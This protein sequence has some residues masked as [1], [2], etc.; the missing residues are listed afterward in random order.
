M[1]IYSWDDA[2]FLD[3]SNEPFR[4][5]IWKKAPILAKPE[6]IPDEDAEDEVEA[7]GEG[8]E[9]SIEA[10][11]AKETRTVSTPTLVSSQN[12]VKARAA[13]KGSIKSV[14][15]IGLSSSFEKPTRPDPPRAMRSTSFATAADPMVT[16]NHADG[17]YV[18]SDDDP[19]RRHDEASA[20]LKDISSKSMTASPSESPQGSPPHESSISFPSNDHSTGISVNTSRESLHATHTPQRS[21]IASIQSFTQSSGPGTPAS[22][23]FD[24]QPPSLNEEPKQPKSFASAAR[25][26]TSTDRKQA[27]AAVNAATAAAQKWG[28]G[29]LNRNKQKEA[30]AANRERVLETPMGRG[31]P[32]PPPGIPLP[33]PERSTMKPNPFTVPKRRPVPPPMLPKRPDTSIN[34]QGSEV[35]HSSPKP[36][37]P[38]R[39]NRQS[40]FQGDDE[41]GDEVLVVEAPVES[42]PTSPA[43]DEHHDD[44]FG[45]GEPESQ[46]VIREETTD[47]E[48]EA[49]KAPSAENAPPEDQIGAEQ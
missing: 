19:L 46:C 5:G 42:A 10:L 22:A 18:K 39:R 14:A 44:F 1:E 25:S 29:V 27:L 47:R 9:Y 4:G 12:G 33:P 28:W 2:A 20:I 17:D 43:V 40:S 7:C 11:K 3:T 38:E 41:H 37:L 26:L 13:K 48:A 15:D 21:S 49:A 36:A 30:E 45:H 16:A 24:S 23:N 32:L 35:S 31:R 6:N 34:G 8:T